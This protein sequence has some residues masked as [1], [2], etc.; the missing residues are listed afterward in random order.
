MTANEARVI[1]K[2]ALG[3]NQSN[4]R[5]ISDT[6]E[7]AAKQGLTEIVANIAS[8]ALKI[9]LEEDGFEVRSLYDFRDNT[10]INEYI[11]LWQ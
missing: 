11:I 6:I 9:K 7:K 1:T 2:N 8:K 4:Y 10:G 5:L 3:Y